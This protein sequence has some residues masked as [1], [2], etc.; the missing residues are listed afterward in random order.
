[1]LRTLLFGMLFILGPK[2]SFGQEQS[3]PSLPDYTDVSLNNTIEIQNLN[4][5]LLRHL[6]YDRLDA[7]PV[8]GM[9]QLGDMRLFILG[10]EAGDDIGFPGDDFTESQMLLRM[11]RIYENQG[12]MLAAQARGDSDAFEEIL[13]ASMSALSILVDQP[14]I[15]ENAQYREL[16]RSVVT[17]YERYYGFADS[18]AIEQGDIFDARNEA[19]YAINAEDRAPLENITLPQI[20]FVGT[21]IPM[22]INDR[23][24]SSIVFLLKEPDKHINNWLGRAETYF[25]MIEKIFEEEGVP[26]EL[27]YL[28]M[29]ESGLNPNAKS[30]ARAVGMWQFIRATGK[31]YGLESNGWVEDRMNPEKATRAAARHLKDLHRMFGDWQL[32]LAGYNYSPGKL[33]RHLRRAQVNLDRK[34]TYWDVYDNLPR[35][36][37][38]YVPMFIATAIVASNPKEFGLGDG[39]VPGPQYEFDYVPIQGMLSL[40]DAAEMAGTDLATI[41]ALNPELRG[42]HL[43]PS[44]TAYYL[45]IP[46]FSYEKFAEGYRQIPASMKRAVSHHRVKRGETL[47]QVARRYGVSVS[48][49]MRKNGLRSTIINIGQP[50]VVPVTQYSSGISSSEI[51]SGGISSNGISMADAKP[52]R[53]Q[54]GMRSIRPI[55]PSQKTALDS[56]LL[57][58]R[59]EELANKIPVVKASDTKPAP[60]EEKTTAAP[61]KKVEVAEAKLE[62]AQ[63]SRVVY[64]VRKGDTLSRIAQQ[65]KVSVSELRKWNNMSNSLIKI[66][67]RLTIYAN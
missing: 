37:R 27:K 36:T 64:R 43:P 9:P 38:N 29:I 54:Y 67:Q 47:G 10:D 1:M 14:A 23:V 51:A 18:L 49:L 33:R 48:S 13:D 42:T 63:P 24:K 19:F 3:Q 66:G 26:D 39:V 55:S 45:R 28:A 53:I 25:P 31:A 17:E 4:H 2:L 61:E 21:D 46:L 8:Q 16:Y 44:K 59:A 12:K 40:A 56:S 65:F 35:E 58:A 62:T 41:K 57:I 11:S 7:L 6:N 20:E 50:L 30:W 5:R 32:A 15:I 34:A 22:T 52:M 60:K